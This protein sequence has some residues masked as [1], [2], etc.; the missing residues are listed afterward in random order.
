[1][2]VL[3][4]RFAACQARFTRAPLAEIYNYKVEADGFYFAI[5]LPIP[6]RPQW[7]C[8]FS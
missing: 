5:T 4:L 2:Q 8:V 6:K 1:M 7:R 3:R